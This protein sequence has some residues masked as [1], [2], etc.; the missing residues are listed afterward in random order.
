MQPIFCIY[1]RMI[2]FALFD[3][4]VGAL[5]SHQKSELDAGVDQQ[6]GSL[7]DFCLLSTPANSKLPSSDFEIFFLLNLYKSLASLV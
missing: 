6:N 5:E 1:S 4:I 2:N 3:M 7:L